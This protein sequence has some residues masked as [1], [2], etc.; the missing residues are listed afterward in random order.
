MSSPSP[1]LIKMSLGN[2]PRSRACKNRRSRTKGK[3]STTRA[4]TSF[5]SRASVRLR[6]ARVESYETPFGKNGKKDH[7]TR[8]ASRAHPCSCRR[9]GGASATRGLSK[10]PCALCTAHRRR[11]RGNARRG[12]FTFRDGRDSAGGGQASRRGAG[13]TGEE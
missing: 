10:Q 12:G 4:N 3:V 11:A 6:N 5:A 9:D 8:S 2:L 7:H 13:D 1:A